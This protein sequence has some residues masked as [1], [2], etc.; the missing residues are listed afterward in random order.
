MTKCKNLIVTTFMSVKLRHLIKK[1]SVFSPPLP[2]KVGS[3][4]LDISEPKVKALTDVLWTSF[5][6]RNA[7]YSQNWGYFKHLY[8]QK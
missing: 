8:R 7:E 5:D 2:K 6:L 1:N 3:C 4:G